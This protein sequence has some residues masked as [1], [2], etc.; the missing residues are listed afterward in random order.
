MIIIVYTCILCVILS[1]ICTKQMHTR[2]LAY[3]LKLFFDTVNY[4]LYK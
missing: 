1:K 3:A 2:M 4:Y